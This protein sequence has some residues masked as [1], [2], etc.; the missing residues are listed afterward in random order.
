MKPILFA[1]LIGIII[2]T[3]YSAPAPRKLQS[4]LQ[5][6]MQDAD[7][8]DVARMQKWFGIAKRVIAG[9]N[10]AVNGEKRAQLESDDSDEQKGDQEVARLVDEIIM[11]IIEAEKEKDKLKREE[12]EDKEGGGDKCNDGEGSEGSE[13]SEGEEGSEGGEGSEDG[14]GGE[15]TEGEDNM[16]KEEVMNCIRQKVQEMGQK[17]DADSKQELARD[18]LKCIRMRVDELHRTEGGSKADAQFL[19]LA[20]G[21]A[22]LVGGLLG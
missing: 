10:T 6:L 14:E 20:L 17:G 1:V 21:A 11:R 8:D 18:V 12:G 13:G 9:L 5:A 16:D 22:S 7:D 2:A 15:G 3:A 19:G 4:Q